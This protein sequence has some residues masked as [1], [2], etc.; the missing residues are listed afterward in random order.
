MNWLRQLFLGNLGL[1]ALSLLLAFLLWLQVASL[2]TVQRNVSIPVEFVNMPSHLEISNEYEKR[3][4]VI[5]RSW[6]STAAID[7][8]QMSAVV[9]LQGATSG[10]E[11]LLLSAENIKNK[12]YGVEILSVNPPRIR[13][14][15]EPTLTRVVKVQPSVIGEPAA[16]Y[17]LTS[18]EALPGEVT[19]SGPQSRVEGLVRVGTEPTINIEGLFS[20]VQQGVFVD[21]QDPQ[22]RIEK[23]VSVM[24]LI[25]IQEKRRHVRLSGV[26]IQVFPKGSKVR[27]LSRQL[28]VVGTLPISYE[29]NVRA[30]DLSAVVNLENLAVRAE[31]YRLVPE[32]VVPQEV[33]G[34]FHVESLKPEW[35]EVRK[36][37]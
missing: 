10:T 36:V 20:S 25:T 1:K 2:Q 32:I 19:V 4:E 18:S 31:P 29:G 12:P 7:G 24:V 21:L 27:L 26:P 15:L 16:G 14:A 37:R 5:V 13:L 35:I 34:L 11:L 6:R 8:L 17:E 22:L 33:Q 23:S 30:A 9:D 28:E 3:V